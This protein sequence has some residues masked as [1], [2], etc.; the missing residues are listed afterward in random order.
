M[1]IIKP[2]KAPEERMTLEPVS[3]ADIKVGDELYYKNPRFPALKA[4]IV[5]IGSISGDVSW[6]TFQECIK[7]ALK[8]QGSLQGFGNNNEEAREL[9]FAARSRLLPDSPGDYSGKAV[10]LI[11]TPPRIGKGGDQYRKTTTK[12]LYREVKS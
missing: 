1:K 5:F 8:G 10:I 4:R 7:E 11:R 2:G 9:A 6:S 12:R 3:R